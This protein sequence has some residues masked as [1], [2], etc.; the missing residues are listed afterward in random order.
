V[1]GS[2]VPHLQIRQGIYRLRMRVPDDLRSRIGMLEVTRSL[3]TSSL[4]KA[5]RLVT[6]YSA[7][8]AGAFNMLRSDNY[9]KE[10]ARAVI[11]ACFR[12]L[13]Q[14]ADGG[15]SP[16]AK[17]VDLAVSEQRGMADEWIGEV[18]EYL[19][20][21]QF[22]EGFTK[23]AKTVLAAYSVDVASLPAEALQDLFEGYARAVIEQQRLFKFRLDDRLATFAPTDALFS[24]VLGA[25]A[26]ALQ[27][28]ADIDEVSV[29]EL[30]ERYLSEKQAAW[31]A[32]TAGPTLRRSLF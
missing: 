14:E 6:A 27:H 32:K 13:A 1:S 31:T 17:D 5:H 28:G 11:Q 25:S 30:A 18:S 26:G 3:Q 2:R 22:T 9:T 16:V 7:R 12:D 23:K 8:L 15:L 4:P 19:E 29:G 20:R 24:D 21:R 10:R